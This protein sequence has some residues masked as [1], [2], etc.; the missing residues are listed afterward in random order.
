[1]KATTRTEAWT[2]ANEIFPT[3]YTLNQTAS[4]RAGYNVYASTLEGCAAW[5]SD[6]GDRLEIN[7]SNGE[8]VNIWIEENAPQTEKNAPQ[9]ETEKDKVYSLECLI[10][11]TTANETSNSGF[12]ATL[13]IDD[14]L[15]LAAVADFEHSAKAMLKKARAAVK[16]GGTATLLLSVATYEIQRNPTEIQQTS[17]NLWLADVTNDDPGIYF[18]PAKK[19][20]DPAKDFYIE[21]PT[22]FLK[23]LNI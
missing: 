16:N 4:E 21:T 12:T 10:T 6:L 5:I 3:D 8:T 7:L 23:N 13:A 2:L 15:T 18:K 11:R 17:Y 1:M 20:D 9:R 22:E 14:R 19:N